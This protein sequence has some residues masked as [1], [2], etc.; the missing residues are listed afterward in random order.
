MYQIKIIYKKV[1]TG[2]Y[3]ITHPVQKVFVQKTAQLK[4]P[5]VVPSIVSNMAPLI[6]YPIY[7]I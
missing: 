4:I 2:H 7:S 1:G 6:C 5:I 3:Y